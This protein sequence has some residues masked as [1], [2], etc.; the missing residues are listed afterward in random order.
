MKMQL[1]F[2]LSI[3]AL[4]VALGFSH[5]AQEGGSLAAQASRQIQ[6][7]DSGLKPHHYTW[8]APGEDDGIAA[9]LRDVMFILIVSQ[10][11]L[12]APFSTLLPTMNSSPTTAGTS[13]L[14]RPLMLSEAP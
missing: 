9:F 13:L 3:G 14:T 7:R 10:S 12:L 2:G 5:F 6:N 11:V 4:P 1:S 8:T